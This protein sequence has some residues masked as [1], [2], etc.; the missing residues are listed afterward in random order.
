M[1]G[2]TVL[3]G[4]SAPKGLGDMAKCLDKLKL[5]STGRL[6]IGYFGLLLSP[7]LPVWLYS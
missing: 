7:K 2:G 5:V 4:H 1:D 3:M 6:A